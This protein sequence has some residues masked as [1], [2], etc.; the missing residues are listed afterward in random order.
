MRTPEPPEIHYLTLDEA[1]IIAT[2]LHVHVRDEN[3]LDMSIARPAAAFGGVEQFPGM[4]LK[5]ASIMDA[6][7][8]SHPMIDG[9]KRMSY[10]LTDA[11]CRFHYMA[12]NPAHAEDFIVHVA[13]DHPPLQEIE[14]WIAQNHHYVD[15]DAF[16][17][18]TLAEHI[19]D[20]ETFWYDRDRDL[21]YSSTPHPEYLVTAV[22]DGQRWMVRIGALDGLTQARTEDEIEEVAREFIAAAKG[23]EPDSFDI[24]IHQIHRAG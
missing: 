20:A 19:L 8:R 11:F 15:S 2:S 1:L 12:L 21:V 13:N 23:V 7:N 17:D 22:P 18:T 10:A 5:A 6:I 16:H 9:N 14:T 4:F 24:E 3:L